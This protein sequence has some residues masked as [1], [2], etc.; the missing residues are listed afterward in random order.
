MRYRVSAIYSDGHVTCRELLTDI[1]ASQAFEHVR[2]CS[3]V[4]M[5]IKLLD[6]GDTDRWEAV[7]VFRQG[8][9]TLPQQKELF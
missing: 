7:E 2:K 3:T 5:V 4:L 8:A 9:A 1:G 6:E